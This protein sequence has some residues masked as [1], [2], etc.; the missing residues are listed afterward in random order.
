MTEV[1]TEV[2]GGA[3]TVDPFVG[4]F[5]GRDFLESWWDNL[6]SGNLLVAGNDVSFLPLVEQSGVVRC[7]GDADVTDYHSV[8]GHDFDV[9][10]GSLIEHLRGNKSVVL[11]SL[12]ELS[13]YGLET[14]LGRL[15]VPVEMVREH[16]GTAVIEVEA[17]YLGGLPKKQRHELR[18]KHRRYQE[19]AGD[20]VLELST[21]VE[22]LARFVELHRSSPGEKGDFFD[23]SRER[24]FASLTAS[25]GWEFAELTVGATVVAS[26]FGYRSIDSYY[27]YNSA[28]DPMFREVSPGIVV[29]HQLIEHLVNSGCRRIDLLKGD[30]TYKF[31]M[32][33]VERHLYTIRIN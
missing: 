14:A 26:L 31:R 25:N 28:I 4:P 20:A 9:V 21:G 2:D 33:A 16:P 30:E 29:L 18:R 13:A 12:P 6:G 15:E 32:G 19:A 5:A 11:D 8:R 3:Q 7:A 10:A 1:W 24:F 27:L 23:T 22:P 17:D